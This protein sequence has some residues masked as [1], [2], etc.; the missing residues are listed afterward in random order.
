[1]AFA[2]KYILSI[3]ACAIICSVVKTWIPKN[4][5]YHSMVSILTGLILLLTAIKP[6]LRLEC[7]DLG[8]NVD[9][10]QTETNSYTQS[11]QA[12]ASEA[13]IS[14]IKQQTEAYIL[15]KAADLEGNIAVS[16]ALDDSNMIPTAVTISGDISPYGREALSIYMENSLGIPKEKQIWN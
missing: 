2:G 12:S 14:I 9:R 1:M 4:S 8:V 16:V 15:D 13:M 10:W 11:G 7:L 6:M 5:A 3:I